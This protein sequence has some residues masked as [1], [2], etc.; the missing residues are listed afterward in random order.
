MEPEAEPKPPPTLED[1]FL[2]TE[3]DM[4]DDGCSTERGSDD[5]GTEKGFDTDEEEALD[6]IFEAVSLDE[7]SSAAQGCDAG[8]EIIAQTSQCGD[9]TDLE[10][11]VIVGEDSDLG[12][13]SDFESISDADGASE[14]DS[15]RPLLPAVKPTRDEPASHTESVDISAHATT[16][17]PLAAGPDTADIDKGWESESLVGLS[18]DEDYEQVIV[19]DWEIETEDLS[20]NLVRLQPTTKHTGAERQSG[21]SLTRPRP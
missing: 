8:E 3:E 9:E 5:D 2:L 6:S 16:R 12:G 7:A 14:S 17:S 18:S 13:I 10:S 21:L 15:C 11:I 4:C 1:M 20:S 19:E